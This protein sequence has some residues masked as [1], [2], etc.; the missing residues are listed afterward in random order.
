MDER[1]PEEKATPKPAKVKTWKTK[2]GMNETI[3]GLG[4]VVN[5]AALKEPFVIKAIEAYENRTGKHIF[6]TIVVLKD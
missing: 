6:G 5:D 1:K 3:P 2:S 4:F